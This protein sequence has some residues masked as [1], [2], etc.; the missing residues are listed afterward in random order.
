MLNVQT[1]QSLQLII[2]FLLAYL[3]SVTLAGSFR[4]WVA[5]KLGDST[6]AEL[7]FLTL[8]PLAHI[9]FFG[10]VCL[11]L[12]QFGWGKFVPINPLRFRTKY[13]SL[14]LL[15]AI[16]SDTF[17]HMT[18][19]TTG[20]ASLI[21]IFGQKILMI[22]QPL[23]QAFPD[24]SSFTLAIAVIMHSI[25]VLNIMLAV[26]SFILST[27][28]IAVT[29]FLERYTQYQPYAEIIMILLPLTILFL[30]ATPLHLM[31]AWLITHM[32]FFIANLFHIS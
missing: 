5:K 16:L 31:V 3:I 12:F 20:F 9:D 27:C 28:G 6:A 17:A 14:K 22:N 25:I 2:T 1:A 7:G 24:A 8:N 26:V 32:G 23:S 19:A 30:F 13:G 11:F 15:C 18:L 4:A 29:F 10:I 21:F